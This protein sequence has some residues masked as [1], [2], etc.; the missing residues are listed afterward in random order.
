[1]SELW[2]DLETIVDAC[3]AELDGLSPASAADAPAVRSAV[4]KAIG[5][6]LFWVV[7]NRPF[8]E[9]A[10]DGETPDGPFT[11]TPSGGEP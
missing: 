4:A 9:L 1:M 7:S 10:P 11:F 6:T 8:L 5:R 3:V 2:P